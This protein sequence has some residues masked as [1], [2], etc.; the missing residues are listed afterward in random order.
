MTAGS[1]SMKAFVRQISGPTVAASSST[2]LA[3]FSSRNRRY[4]FPKNLRY[5]TDVSVHRGSF[6]FRY[7]NFLT[8]T[9]SMVGGGR[10]GDS[11]IMIR[12]FSNA[13][14]TTAGAAVRRRGSRSAYETREDISF[15][16]RRKSTTAIPS[17]EQDTNFSTTRTG[18]GC[19][20]LIPPPEAFP[21]DVEMSTRLEGGTQTPPT[22]TTS[23]L[24]QVLLF[25]ERQA[26]EVRMIVP[27]RANAVVDTTS[28]QP[29]QRPL[30][31]VELNHRLRQQRAGTRGFATGYPGPPVDPFSRCT[32][33]VMENVLRNRRY[34]NRVPTDKR[35]L[36][37]FAVS[38]ARSES[39][40]LRIAADG[41][42]A[43]GNVK[44]PT[45][46]Q[47]EQYAL[48]C[49][50]PMIG[51]G[52]MDNMIMITVGDL[53][54][55]HFSAIVSTL[56]AAAFGQCCSDVCGTSFSGFVDAAAAKLGLPDARV[57]A[58]QAD[59]TPVRIVRTGSMVI[60][61]ICGCLL[62]MF[63][64]L[65]I[66]TKRNERRK[67]A[68]ELRSLFMSVAEE[69][70]RSL[71]VERC[72]LYIDEDGD[73]SSMWALARK[74]SPSQEQLDDCI[75]RA[76]HGQ[77]NSDTL[78]ITR[79]NNVFKAMKFRY[80]ELP[81][82]KEYIKKEELPLLL[83]QMLQSSAK[84]DKL[85]KKRIRKNGTKYIVLKSLDPDNAMLN[86]AD[87]YADQRFRASR[88]YDTNARTRTTSENAW[89]AHSV[90]IGP[91]LRDGKIVGCIEMINKKSE[92]DLRGSC[93][94]FTKNDERLMWLLC[95]HCSIF[96][97]QLENS[98]SLSELLLTDVTA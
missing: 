76:A 2:A 25:A 78:S 63:P 59:L 19:T 31:R 15:R 46:K 23:S 47:Y 41:L 20:N 11:R 77:E 4:C 65:F 10:G 84:H 48:Q 96:L 88:K 93:V 7:R 35:D 64:L 75:R 83:K 61:V 5:T 17:K 42:T 67:K 95:N 71:N 82:E 80:T 14:C 89:R 24:E 60:G 33:C 13:S 6:Q 37:F 43:D 36:F 39:A 54:D 28:T 56:T 53:I 30:R 52:F 91:V 74:W 97:N 58:A 16:F 32:S 85:E 40:D 27:N 92:P 44:A 18:G 21:E 72:A 94:P 98:E 90:L 66:D 81:T 9:S 55:S 73:A 26:K 79:L 57:T 87:V 38:T 45:R 29:W 1:E 62:G 12:R 22:R 51:F 49:A 34:V 68:K 86:L 70:Q 8:K 3:G 50:V 69:G